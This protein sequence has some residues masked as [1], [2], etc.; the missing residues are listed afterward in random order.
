[1]AGRIP[2]N[3]IDELLGRVDIVE[4]IDNHVPLKKKGRE[5]TA[6]C[7]FHTEK[8]PSFTV[9][10]DKQF[11][12]CFGCGVHGTALGFIMDYTHSDF[13]EAIETLA[14]IAGI[15]IPSEPATVR[16]DYQELYDVLAKASDFYY[17]ALRNNTAAIDY[18]KRRG[19]SGGAAKAFQIGF[20]PAGFDTLVKHIGEEHMPIMIQAGLVA[21]NDRGNRYDRFR[22]R[23]M[24]P[25]RDRRGRT[26]AF[27][28]RALEDISPKYLNSPD[29]PLFHKGRVLY[30]LYE[31]RKVMQRPAYLLLVEG[32]MDVV[33]LAEHGINNAVAALGMATSQQH[34]EQMYRQTRE[35]IFC[36]DGDKAGR[37]AAWRACETLLPIYQDGLEAKFMFL[38]EGDDPDSLVRRLGAEGFTE[39]LKAALPLSEYIFEHEE[40]DISMASLEGRARLA[41]KIKPILNR[42]PHGVF[43]QLMTT[44][45][46]KRL[47]VAVQSKRLL[48][49]EANPRSINTQFSPKTGKSKAVRTAIML[50]L[51]QPSLAQ[52]IPHKMDTESLELPGFELL[53][54]VVETIA[55]SPNLTSAGLVEH[56]RDTEY[57]HHLLKLLQWTPPAGFQTEHEFDDS[58]KSIQGKS[59]N[60]RKSKLLRKELDTGLSEAEKQELHQLLQMS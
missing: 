17:Q 35:I 51:N 23:I 19:L 32:Y 14:R 7:P 48:I 4:V 10:Q 39:K 33:M 8:T 24:F 38:D 47:G 41:E 15:E 45:L 6:C 9:S 60:Q 27:G 37:N 53:V 42:L 2:Q 34:L 21:E 56:F 52:R 12:H 26:I 3:F 44:Q 57:Y 18:L 5:Y 11:Y 16:Q 49:G 20:A 46:E 28:G 31:S 55:N 58:I 25:I 54:K 22:N 40:E 30:G 13:L 59:R 50:L 43:R 36:F 29:T 1:M